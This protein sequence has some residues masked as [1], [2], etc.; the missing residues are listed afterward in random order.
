VLRTGGVLVSLA[1]LALFAFLALAVRSRPRAVELVARLVRPL[2]SGTAERIASRL[3]AFIHGLRIV[4]SRGKL[5]L[6]VSLTVGYWGL[7]AFGMSLLARGFGFHLGVVES[8]TLLGVLVVGV[9]IPSGPGMVGTFQGAIVVGLSLFASREAVATAGTA[10]AN[11]LWAVQL[12]VQTALGVAF[13]FS[14]HIRL[15]QIFAAPA[16]VGS[17][18]DAEE[19]EYRRDER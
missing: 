7:N 6:F 9:M 18:L 1:F 4:P 10:Y 11:V 15:A 16:E 17:G 19:V 5:V 14:R 2:S 13:L 12:A 3:D 8:C